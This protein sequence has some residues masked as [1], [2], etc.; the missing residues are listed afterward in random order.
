VFGI[1]SIP[2]WLWVVPWHLKR[3]RQARS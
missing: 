1:V 3:R 2:Y